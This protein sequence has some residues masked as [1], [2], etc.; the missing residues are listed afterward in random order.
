MTVTCV[1]FSNPEDYREKITDVITSE[2][3]LLVACVVC[4]PRDMRF[5]AHFHEECDSVQLRG[6]LPGD[7]SG[8]GIRLAPVGE[9]DRG[10]LHVIPIRDPAESA[11]RTT[12]LRKLPQQLHPAE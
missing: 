1:D 9:S 12:P 5:H 8:G 6:A 3:K 10:K 4:S 11:N 2:V 7:C